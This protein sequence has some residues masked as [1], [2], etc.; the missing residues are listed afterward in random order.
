[1]SVYRFN[2]KEQRAYF[3]LNNSFAVRLR[4]SEDKQ[5]KTYTATAINIS[6]GGLCIEVPDNQK[7]LIDKLCAIKENSNIIIE[8]SILN[9]TVE[10]LTKPAWTNCRLNWAR[11]P[12]NKHPVFLAGLAFNNL[13]ED[14]RK[15]IHEYLI[16]EFVKYYDKAV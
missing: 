10:L 11:K 8:A 1:M 4:F 6:H 13:A 15:Q 7:E 16:E 9:S 3:R 12:T 2:G 5:D 14:T